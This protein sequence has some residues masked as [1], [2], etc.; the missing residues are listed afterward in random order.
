MSKFFKVK[1]SKQIKSGNEVNVKMNL[2]EYVEL[3]KMIYNSRFSDIDEVKQSLFPKLT[4]FIHEAGYDNIESPQEMIDRYINRADVH[5][6]SEF[7]PNE[8][9][10]TW[11]E[12]CSDNAIL[13]ND[14]YAIISF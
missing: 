5:Y 1:S 7:E 10:N 8:T 6:R 3:L 13:W 11:E 12:Y 2:D 14:E 9:Y 4:E